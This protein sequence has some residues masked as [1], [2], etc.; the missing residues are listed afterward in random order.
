MKK[1]TILYGIR[2]VR[3]ARVLVCMKGEV[4]TEG[5]KKA[6]EGGNDNYR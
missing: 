1:P 3:V 5:Q 4:K 6:K 2:N